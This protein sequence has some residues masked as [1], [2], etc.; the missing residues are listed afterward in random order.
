MIARELRPAVQLLVAGTLF[1]VAVAIVGVLTALADAANGVT[2]F[3]AMVAIALPVVG[4]LASRSTAARRNGANILAFASATVALA[5]VALGAVLLVILLLGRMPRAGEKAAVALSA[6]GAGAAALCYR[7]A[8]ERLREWL[9]R[10]TF[11]VRR[12]PEEV[13]RRFGDR[14]NRGLPADELLLEL[15]ESLRRTM[16]LADVELW[17]KAPGGIARAVS[18]PERAPATLRPAPQVADAL[19]R[20][21]IAGRRWMDIWL[22]QLLDGHGDELRVTSAAYSGELL[23]LVVVER[24]SD[25]PFSQ[26]DDLALAELGRRLGVV[27]HNRQLDAALQRSL[28]DLQHANEELRASRVRLV[29]S[30]DEA[31]RRIERDLHDGAQQHLAALAINLRIARDVVATDPDAAAKV[32]DEL[33]Q[34]VRETIQEIRDLAHGIYPPLLAKSGLTEALAAAGARHPGDVIV[35]TNGIGRYSGDLE[36][37]VYFCCLEALQNSAKHAPDAHVKVRVWEDNQVLRF[38]VSDDGPGFDIL[39]VDTGHGLQNMSDRLGAFGGVVTWQ[40]EPGRG[41]R[42]L[43]WLPIGDAA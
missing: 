28:D 23:G 4:A 7:P 27:L 19:T 11:G 12:P 41:T 38:E 40:S 39:T 32:L 17:T 34:A 43:G 25:D 20:T 18:I 9:V 33:G 5:V 24:S 6:I 35:D 42:V 15:A 36:A 30:A 29:N 21:P 1:A 2:L 22:P 14:A 16:S 31:R 3:F 8:R 37:A 13:V 10:L 26:D